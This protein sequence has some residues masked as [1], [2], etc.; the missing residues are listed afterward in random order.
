MIFSWQKVLKKDDLHI[1]FGDAC[2]QEGGIFDYRII[3]TITSTGLEGLKGSTPAIRNPPLCLITHGSDGKIGSPV[4]HSNACTAP[5]ANAFRNDSYQSLRRG[6]TRSI[7]VAARDGFEVAANIGLH[8]APFLRQVPISNR[9]SIDAKQQSWLPSAARLW[10]RW[11]RMRPIF[12]HGGKRNMVGGRK[13]G[14]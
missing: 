1:A 8:A 14:T 10:C 13:G 4:D 11:L 7:R 5:M 3:L 12:D 2:S 6:S 9:F